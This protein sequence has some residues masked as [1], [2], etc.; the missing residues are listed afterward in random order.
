MAGLGLFAMSC[1]KNK[2]VEPV[3]DGK[4]FRF[5]R[6]MVSDEKTNQIT[7]VDAKTDVTQTFDAKFPKSAIYTTD[8][9]RFGGIIHQDNNLVEHFDTGFE[10][11]GDHVDVKGTPKFA[12]L[13]GERL[14][15]THYGSHGDEIITFNDG[16]GSMSTAKETD[17]HKVGMK[18]QTIPTGNVAHHG[19]MVKFSNGNYAVTHKVGSIVGTLP[20]RVKIIDKSGKLIAQSTIQTK[21]IHGNNSDGKIALLVRQVEF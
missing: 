16:D 2:D 13:I 21:G 7:L 18:M 8:A 20:E 10:Y 12:A 3:D 4:E 9:G 1:D 19:A 6:L 5:I 11:H 17:L 15:P 14:K